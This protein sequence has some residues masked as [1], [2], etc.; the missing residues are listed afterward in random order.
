[1]LGK[2]EKSLAAWSGDWALRRALG[3]EALEDFR[4]NLATWLRD[5]ALRRALG[6]GNRLEIF[7]ARFC[8]IDSLYIY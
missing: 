3:E 1:M 4:R 8:D 2:L 6:A 7:Q 5:W